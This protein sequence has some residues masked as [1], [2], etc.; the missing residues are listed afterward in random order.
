[1]ILTFETITTSHESKP[2]Q[3]HDTVQFP[4]FKV[5][6]KIE[7]LGFFELFPIQ[8]L[9]SI[10]AKISSQKHVYSIQKEP[11][12]YASSYHQLATDYTNYP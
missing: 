2:L 4:S 5:I 12:S 11:P 6:W 10:F 1:M 9:I 7:N 8:K 3:F